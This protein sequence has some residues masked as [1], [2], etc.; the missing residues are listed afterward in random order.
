MKK[1]RLI[2]KE[3]L[4]KAVLLYKNGDSTRD[5][6]KKAGITKAGLQYQLK[7]QN[8]PRRSKLEGLKLMFKKTRGIPDLDVLKTLY[9]DQKWSLRKI[10]REFNICKGTVKRHLR[11]A[12]LKI[13]DQNDPLV[14]ESKIRKGPKNG[15]WSGGRFKTHDG[16]IR[17]LC[18]S[19]PKADCKGY[20]AEQNL[21]WEKHNGPLP[22][23]YVVHHKNGIKDDNSIENLEA[24]PDA[25]HKQLHANILVSDGK[26][27]GYRLN[28]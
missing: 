16:Y 8:I 27:G 11:S 5:A 7:K 4:N 18:S 2:D 26:I 6:A 28:A 10:G 1:S 17:V 15:R 9:Y 22:D 20:V 13:R 23:N 21:I 19:H 14:Q 12:G 3:K 24:M 25:A